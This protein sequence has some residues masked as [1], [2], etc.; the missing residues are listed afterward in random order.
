M[1]PRWRQSAVLFALNT[2]E[3]VDLDTGSYPNEWLDEIWCDIRVHYSKQASGTI[4]VSLE[5][6]RKNKKANIF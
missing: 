3:P 6:V 2:T 4:D 5:E 1:S